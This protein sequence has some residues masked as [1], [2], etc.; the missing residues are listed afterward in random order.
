MLAGKLI[1]VVDD[2]GGFL[3]GIERLLKAHGLKV[4]T[5]ASAEEF[6]AY[7]DPAEAACLILDIHLSGIS[8]IEL[9]R[10][11][12][13]AGIRIPVVLVTANDSETMRKAAT[14]AGCSA[15]LEKPFSAKVLMDA[16]N[17]AVAPDVI[18]RS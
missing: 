12:S 13:G 11:L 5:F 8:G 1:H 15:Y 17:G 9:L 7:A 10:R 4:K 18:R 6:Q 14:D 16:I 2:D 3:K